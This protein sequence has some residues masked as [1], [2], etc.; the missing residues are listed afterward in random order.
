MKNILAISLACLVLLQP[1]SK[2]SIWFVFQYNQGYIAKT[3]CK[4]KDVQ[5]NTCQGHCMLKKQMQAASED[6]P[7]NIPETLKDKTETF[8]FAVFSV[9]DWQKHLRLIERISPISFDS[10][11]LQSGFRPFVFHP[12]AF[13]A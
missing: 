9:L 2:L 1:L 4:Q 10:S 8:Y 12:P 11:M 5:E 6:A 7:L 3:L 13:L